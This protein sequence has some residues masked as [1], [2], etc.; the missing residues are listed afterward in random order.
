MTDLKLSIQQLRK[1]VVSLTSSMN[2]N[3][4]T[5]L[6]VCLA[7]EQ[8][9]ETRNDFL[10][11]LKRLKNPKSTTDK[12]INIKQILSRIESIME[13][14]RQRQEYIESG[15]YEMLDDWDWD[16]D[17]YHYDSDPDALSED[18]QEELN[19]ITHTADV[20]FLDKDY[21]TASTVYHA[22]I[23]FSIE[24]NAEELVW[25]DIFEDPSVY[26]R[27]F[28]AV[29]EIT[30][31]AE[32]SAA[33]FKAMSMWKYP[34][35]T[36]KEELSFRGLLISCPDIPDNLESFLLQWE[37]FLK[38]QNSQLAECLLLE[39]LLLQDK[40]EAARKQLDSLGDDNPDAWKVYLQ[41]LKE[42]G[43][44]KALEEGCRA[45]LDIVQNSSFRKIFADL[46]VFCGQE[47]GKLS[48]VADGLFYRIVENGSLKL[49]ST[50]L[51]LIPEGSLRKELLQRIDNAMPKDFFNL[52]HAVIK[53]LQ[54]NI[55][56]CI[57]LSSGKSF[58][59]WSS[60][61]NP[62]PVVVAGTFLTVCKTEQKLPK[63]IDLFCQRYLTGGWEWPDTSLISTDDKD[64][65]INELRKSLQ[66]PQSKHYSQLLDWAKDTVS[67]RADYI[68]SNTHRRAY[69]RAAE[70]L[71]AWS[72]AAR[73]NGNPEE[74][75][76][77]ITTFHKK[78]NRHRAFRSC[79]R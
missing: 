70:G 43:N 60:E 29:Y 64:I 75:T 14:V 18:L 34:S 62:L 56:D 65:L 16:D 6:L 71:K 59:G 11:T 47:S 78:Y 53:M 49:I 35:G 28:R 24:A 72:E 74:A 77:L 30:P 44:L 66:L 36:I 13:E 17:N 26:S 4:L 31:S 76:L 50:M 23:S 12:S 2:Q 54:G 10:L 20:C 41:E 67:S 46:L 48:T 9:A 45:A 73:I 52:T 19:E 79:L 39:T 68:V 63:N 3:E 8:P 55:T 22:L 69:G 40:H 25:S 38:N 42:S 57:S 21:K 1:E 58:Y 51:N 15:D 27:Y 5:H 7:E 61:R 37:L 32:K 33:L